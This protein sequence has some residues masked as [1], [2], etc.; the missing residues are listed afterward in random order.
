MG[1]APAERISPPYASW[2]AAAY[3][4]HRPVAINGVVCTCSGGSGRRRREARSRI[5]RPDTVCAGEQQT[6]T[7][8]AL[9]ASDRVRAPKRAEAKVIIAATR[10]IAGYQRALTMITWPGTGTSQRRRG[11]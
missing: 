8:T 10:Y 2:L 6:P 5:R 11:G 9:G 3:R 7:P 4:A 1:D